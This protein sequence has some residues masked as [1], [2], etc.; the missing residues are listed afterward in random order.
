SSPSAT[1]ASFSELVPYPPSPV[2]AT[3]VGRSNWW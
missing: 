2:S 1:L 3:S